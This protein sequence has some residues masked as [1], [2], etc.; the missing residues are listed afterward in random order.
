MA[1]NRQIYITTPLGG[2]SLLFQRM[3]AHEELG[4]LFSYEIDLLSKD[5]DLRPEDLLG[6]EMTVA[7]LLPKGDQRYF[8][9]FVS[10]FSFVGSSGAH[11]EYRATLHPWLWFLTRSADCRI[12]QNKSVPE[13]LKEIFEDFGFSEMVR[14]NLNQSYST[15]E[16]CVQY[17]ETDFNFVSRLMEQEGIYY[18]F[19]H[20]KEKHT[21]V[22]SD[23]YSSHDTVNDYEEL[24]YFPPDR[25]DHRER[26]HINHWQLS[27]VVQPGAYVL[28]DF[29]FEKP[30]SSLETKRIITRDHAMAKFEIFDF[31]G[32][33]QTNADG[34][35]F[36]QARIEELQT[37]HEVV[38][39]AGSARGL[40][41]G[42]LFSLTGYPRSDQNRQYLVVSASYALESDSY[43][44]G[45]SGSGDLFS[46][47]FQAVPSGQP[48]R[49]ARV[50]PKPAVQGP[51]TAMVVGK[52][53][54]E[55]WTDEYGRV[56]I[57]F[58]WDRY[59]KS[60][61]NSSCWVRVS[62]LWA[63]SR[64]GGMHIP[65]IGQE[66]IVEFLEGD[67]D[68]PIITGRV[69]NRDSMPP[70]PLPKHQTRSTV[71]SDSSKGG[72]GCNELRFEDKKGE[73]Q[74]FFHAQKDMDQ[75]VKHDLKEFV[76]NDM[77]LIVKGNRK[78]S[79]E[80][81]SHQQVTG[82]HLEKVDGKLA[83][84]VGTQRDEKVGTNYAVEAGQEIHLKGGTTI[85]IEAGTQLS[86]KA[87]GGFVD[88]GP[89]GV[90]IQGAM[91]KINSGGSAGSGGGCSP[92]DPEAPEE[93]EDY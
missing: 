37:Q 66:V 4:R 61:E 6:Q 70:Y 36:V 24:P 31:P 91:V 21:L 58:H 60:D 34:D 42:H 62:Q 83:L 17:R 2:D 29:D 71:K 64:W 79:V 54:E 78:E 63:G 28:T 77:H 47:N 9:G 5:M 72:G 40:G 65:R 10:Q 26:D 32:E 92:S 84:Q 38:R 43:E 25:H 8:H 50:T 81:N 73:E 69:Y 44:S 75:R 57:Q 88:I 76:G 46:C 12:F 52:A 67:P 14:D 33:Y 7:L 11:A 86:L 45:S 22:L 90:T 16:Y 15:W 85:V 20:D 13:I 53:G 30:K 18:Y 35:Q 87:G 19:E 1:A 56:K 27:Q 39:G 82:N 3:S 74:V 48:F 89:G 23:G 55:I 49:A 80:G 68:A 51:Q 41:A 93:A 59:G